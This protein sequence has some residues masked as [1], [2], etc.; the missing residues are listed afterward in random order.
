MTQ[1]DTSV[2][3]FLM[4]QSHD[5][6][7][8]NMSQDALKGIQQESTLSKAFF[9][10][11]NV[12]LIQKLIIAT[13]FKRSRGK[14]LIERQ[15]D[16]DVQIVMRSIFLQRAKYLPDDIR[17]QIRELDEAVADEVWAG[18]ISEIKAYNGY[19]KRAFGPME[20][21]DRPKNV[22]SAG[23]KMLPVYNR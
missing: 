16:T 3:A 21:M 13:V 14:Y 4:F 10:P 23:R 1:N 11:K 6:F 7:Y 20:I 5:T 18:I 12:D 2:P 17:G 22:S 19:K 15:D 8:H 9:H